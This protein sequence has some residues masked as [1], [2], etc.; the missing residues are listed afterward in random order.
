M[1]LLLVEKSVLLRE[2]LVAMLAG[3][4]GLDRIETAASVEEASA[5]MRAARPDIVVI[6]ACLPDGIGTKVLARIKAECAPGCVI[7][8]S[9]DSAD[10]Y[11]KCWLQAGADHCF[12]INAQLDQLLNAVRQA[13]VASAAVA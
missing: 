10:L 8:L 9:H 1:R 11:R 5:V 7:V 12:D 4:Q 3:I 2:R 13:A 6:D